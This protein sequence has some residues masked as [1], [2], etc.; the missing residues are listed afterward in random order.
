MRLSFLSGRYHCTVCH[1]TQ[2][3]RLLILWVGSQHTTTM[4]IVT[5][6]AYRASPDTKL[7]IGLRVASNSGLITLRSVDGIFA[8]SGLHTGMELLSVNGI[9]TH[10][11]AVDDVV[12]ILSQ[13]M[14]EV[15][16]EARATSP[17]A[18]IGQNNV[19]QPPVAPSND[20]SAPPPL[21]VP[22]ATPP[23]SN[24]P[25]AVFSLKRGQGGTVS[26]F[27]DRLQV[28]YSKNNTVKV[29]HFDE[30]P[31]KDNR[32]IY[33]LD[34]GCRTYCCNAHSTFGCDGVIHVNHCA[35][36]GGLGARMCSTPLIYNVDDPYGL[37]LVWESALYAYK[38]QHCDT[39]FYFPGTVRTQVMERMKPRK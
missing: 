3:Q 7:G 11:M 29:F 20:F 28:V 14:G 17:L 21:P 23:V 25:L 13:V 6:K 9:P 36:L 4:S 10:G 31:N 39:S 35:D 30:S 8:S 5:A 32:Q 26:V 1:T 15:T 27:S 2:E 22:N 24:T 12:A 37:M 33:A 19:S 38:N 18:N 16:L 34:G